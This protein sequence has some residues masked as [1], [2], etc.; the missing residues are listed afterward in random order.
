MKI[1]E[2]YLICLG[3]RPVF[4]FTYLPG[5]IISEDINLCDFP[6]VFLCT[7]S[8]EK[9][10]ILDMREGKRKRRGMRREGNVLIGGRRRK[11]NRRRW[12]SWVLEAVVPV[13]NPPQVVES[14]WAMGE[15]WLGQ[16]NV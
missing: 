15:V 3:Q 2:V 7:A 8:Q 10:Q 13:A 6:T 1:L 12:R 11:P 16:Q 5:R 4:V 9:C 14:F